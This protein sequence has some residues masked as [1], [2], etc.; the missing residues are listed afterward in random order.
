MEELNAFLDEYQAQGGFDALTE[1]Y[2]SE[3]KA[4]FDQWGF[5][6]FFDLEQ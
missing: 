5:T 1:K 3:E 6:W 2:M 4:V